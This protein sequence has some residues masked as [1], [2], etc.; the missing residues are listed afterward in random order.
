MV[1]RRSA[2]QRARQQGAYQILEGQLC[3]TALP[4][5]ATAFCEPNKGERAQWHWFALKGKG[6]RPL[7]AFAGIYREWKGPI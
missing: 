6:D 4:V 7:F 3:Q 2:E 1:T 5:P